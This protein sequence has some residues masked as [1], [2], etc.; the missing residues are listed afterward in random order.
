[1]QKN[2]RPTEKKETLKPKQLR[3]IEELVAGR[4][5]RDACRTVEINESTAHAWMKQ[6]LFSKEYNEA[7]QTAFDEKL[8]MLKSGVSVALRTLLKHM[9]DDETPAYTQVHAAQIWLAQS[10]EVHKVQE[11]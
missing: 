9:T 5:I 4:T 6:P 11:L 2:P 10:F 3:L 1:M 7:K 8:D